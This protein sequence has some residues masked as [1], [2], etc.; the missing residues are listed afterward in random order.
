MKNILL[1]LLCVVTF[2]ACKKEKHEGTQQPE[3]PVTQKATESDFS[4]AYVNSP[5]QQVEVIVTDSAANF[6]LDTLLSVND[7]HS[8]KVYSAQTKFNIT[9]IEHI[10]SINKTN[11]QTFSRYYLIIGISTNPIELVF[12]TATGITVRW[13]APSITTMFLQ[14]CKGKTT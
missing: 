10:D 1:I 13:M 2:T 3:P 8:M 9:T 12:M 4:L 11:V 14:V 5:S 7:M 6:L